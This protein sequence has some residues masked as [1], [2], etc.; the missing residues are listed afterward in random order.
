MKINLYIYISINICHYYYIVFI[1]KNLSLSSPLFFSPLSFEIDCHPTPDPRASK[2]P[3]PDSFNFRRPT[4]IHHYHS[5]PTTQATHSCRDFVELPS[6]SLVIWRPVL[7]SNCHFWGSYGQG[8][9]FLTN[10][11][12]MNPFSSSLY[13][14]Y[15]SFSSEKYIKLS[16]YFTVKFWP[17]SATLC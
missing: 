16:C 10:L 5:K 17:P 11:D 9:S 6:E 2:L 13:L 14:N 15:C 3:P 7:S 8:W 12:L 1:K 4:L